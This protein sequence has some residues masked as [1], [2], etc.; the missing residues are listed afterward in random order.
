MKWVAIAL[1]ISYLTG[2][3][4]DTQAFR[5]LMKDL[6]RGIEQVVAVPERRASALEEIKALRAAFAEYRERL[7]EVGACIER[8]DRTYDVRAEN[9]RA[10]DPGRG[11]RWEDFA[12]AF[13]RFRTTLQT[14]LTDA[15][16]RELDRLIQE[17]AGRL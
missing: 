13:L 10:C 8:W 5:G 15:E 16:W 3:G 11:E 17:K 12:A 14:V 7:S 4:D 1:L 9:Y 6:G 2:S